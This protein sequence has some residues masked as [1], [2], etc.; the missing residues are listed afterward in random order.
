[1]K[2]LQRRV[3]FGDHEFVDIS[4]DRALSQLTEL[5]GLRN[6]PRRIEGYDISHMSGTNVVASMVVFTNGVSDRAEYRKFKM[7]KQTND[8]TANIHDTVFRRLGEKNLSTWG[9]PDLLLIDGGKG[10]LDAAI[11]AQ[12]ARGTTFPIISIA[13][14]E[15]EI[16]VS[17]AGSNVSLDFIRSLQKT[18]S[19]NA[20]VADEGNFYVI[21]LH[22]GQLNAGSHSKNLRG[23]IYDAPSDYSDT[24][25]LFQRIRDEAHRFAVSYH[26]T[27]KRSTQ[28][29]SK[30]DGIPGIGPATRKKLLK[31]FGS[32]KA[33]EQADE[34]DVAKVI[35]PIKA[36]NLR[37]Y[38]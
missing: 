13:K 22:P 30:L 37:R 38:L 17:K 26:S 15:E 23:R 2:E 10:Q 16:I 8:D 9:K 29:T 31:A 19:G 4:K 21:N 25:K 20:V 28:T 27:L 1:M 3:M 18:P 24:V 34:S 12:T 32:V 14:K 6:V 5:L 33:L 35:G 11:T 36:A 7:V